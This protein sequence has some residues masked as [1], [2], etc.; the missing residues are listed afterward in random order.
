MLLPVVAHQR[1]GDDFLA[2]LDPFVAQL[3]E[4]ERVSFAPRSRIH[5]RQSSLSHDVADHV[6]QLQVH[7]VQRL[8]HMVHVGRRHLHQ[9]LSR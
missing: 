5:D 8:L 1:F 7:L 4:P 6:G 2:G 3:R 9:G